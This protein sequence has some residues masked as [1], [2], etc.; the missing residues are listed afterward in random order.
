MTLETICST[1]KEI[2][3]HHYSVKSRNELAKK[4][5]EKIRVR[6][7]NCNKEEQLSVDDFKA[8]INIRLRIY[9]GLIAL[10]FSF[11]LPTF[12]FYRLT[13]HTFLSDSIL[14]GLF[15]AP[16]IL[17]FYYYQQ[18]QKAIQR[19]NRRKL[20]KYSVSTKVNGTNQI[21]KII[22]LERN[23]TNAGTEIHS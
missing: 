9:L 22:P 5:G 10:G 20:R 11:I 14:I 23:K 4:Y 6:C 1:C 18:N 8:V 16:L 12:L 13:A 21:K 15:A 2:T 17:T 19:F 7:C 3:T